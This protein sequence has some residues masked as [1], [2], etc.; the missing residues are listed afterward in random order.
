MVLAVETR[1]EL[2]RLGTDNVTLKL[3]YAGP[4][5]GSVV[6]GLLD[7]MISRGDVEDWLAERSREATKLQS[8][9]LWWAKAAAWIAGISILVSVLVSLIGK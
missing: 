6:P 8:D 1:R 4:G 2:D 7:G 9:T 5:R 3:Q